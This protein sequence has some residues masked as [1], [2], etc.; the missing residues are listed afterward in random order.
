[1]GKTQN[2]LIVVVIIVSYCVSECQMG[3]YLYL[4]DLF[5]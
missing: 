2:T 3:I 5:G 1:M 4:F